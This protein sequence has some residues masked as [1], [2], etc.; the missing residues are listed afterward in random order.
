MAPKAKA[1]AGP[2]PSLPPLEEEVALPAGLEPPP[3]PQLSCVIAHAVGHAFEVEDSEGVRTFDPC[4]QLLD[5]QRQKDLEEVDP[6][7]HVGRE[8]LESLREEGK[9][10][11]CALRRK[12]EAEV[13][14][15]KRRKSNAAKKRL[16]ETGG[17]STP[18]T[19]S[20]GIPELVIL[21]VGYPANVTELEELCQETVFD[22]ASCWV[23]IYYAGVTLK[24]SGGVLPIESTADPESISTDVL[25]PCACEVPEVVDAFFDCIQR[26]ELG[27]NLANATIRTIPDSHTLAS[28]REAEVSRTR[29]AL[30]SVCT[31]ECGRR[32]EFKAWV[33]DAPRLRLPDLR[34]RDT[35]LYERLADSVDQARMDVPLLIHCLCEQVVATQGGGAGCTSMSASLAED[36]RQEQV[37]LFEDFMDATHNL[38]SSEGGHHVGFSSPQL[39]PDDAENPDG[40]GSLVPQLDIA[41]CRHLGQQF[42]GGASVLEAVHQVLGHLNG[43]GKDRFGFPAVAAMSESARCAQRNRFYRHMPQ[44]PIVECE[45]MLLL[46]E[47]EQ[48]LH[49]AQPEREWCLQDRVYHERIG[50]D[51]LLQI[52]LEAVRSEGFVK[53][54]Y[55]PRHD[56]LLLALH[57]R[58]L[59]GCMLWHAWMG[60]LLSPP[61][62]V[63][64]SGGEALCTVPTLNDWQQLVVG[65]GPVPKPP[66]RFLDI[67]A[68]ELGYCRIIEKIY[69]PSDGS[70]ILRTSLQ[71]GVAA[72][73]PRPCAAT[74]DSHQDEH[75]QRADDATENGEEDFGDAGDMVTALAAKPPEA[76]DTD[77]AAFHEVRSAK[78]VKD[79]L[80]FGIIEDGGWAEVRAKLR[81]A[82]DERTRI[83][84]AAAADA[85]A[86]EE[87][88]RK[89]RDEQHA[90][91][92][93]QGLP[94][95]DTDMDDMEQDVTKGEEPVVAQ[96]MTEL[97]I[98][99][100]NCGKLW[101]AL[102][103]GARYTVQMH[104]ARP[105]YQEGA[106][107]FEP[108]ES[109][110]GV[111]S[112]YASVSGLAVQV[113]SDGTVWQTMP[114]HGTSME[115]GGRPCLPGCGLDRE[116]VRTV[117][118]SGVLIRELL[119]GRREIYYPDGVFASRNPLF[120]ELATR[121]EEAR[122]Q[123]GE[124]N[125]R[126]LRLLQEI[127]SVYG[128]MHG[129]AADGPLPA[130]DPVPTIPPSENAKAHGLPGHW[131]VSLPTGQ[132][133]GRA[134]VPEEKAPSELDAMSESAGEADVVDEPP[135]PLAQQLAKLFAGV[136]V[137]EG[138]TIEYEIQ[139]SSSS[140]IIDPHTGQR[141][142]MMIE[143][144]MVFEDRQGNT[145]TC[146]FPDRTRVDSSKTD[147][148][149][150]VSI[151]SVSAARVTCHIHGVPMRPHV[152]VEV[153]CGDGTCLEVV[154]QVVH[155]ETG[156]LVPMDQ[157][158]AE[159]I[160]TNASVKLRHPSGAEIH[161]FGAG[162][163]QVIS[164]Y[165][166]HRHASNADMGSTLKMSSVYTARVD[167]SILSLHD[168]DENVFEVHGNQTLKCTL[169]VD[170]GEDTP[171]P[172]CRV[173]GKAY[174][175][176]GA[177]H[178]QLPSVAPDPRLF[179]IYGDGEAE[180]LVTARLGD[181]ILRSARHDPATVLNFGEPMGRPM[182]TCKCH[183]I[184]RT[185][186]LGPGHVV[187][188][189]MD[190]GLP[191]S[192]GGFEDSQ[193]EHPGG[194]P[195]TFTKFRQLIEYPALNDALRAEFQ[196]ALARHNAEEAEQHA[197]HAHFGQD[198]RQKLDAE[199]KTAR[200]VIFEAGG[201]A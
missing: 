181:E 99:D 178:L 29:T 93:A 6:L 157:S 78:V 173:P 72:T 71:C 51:Q 104:W 154:P 44:T 103:G 2:P 17:A 133:Y 32:A 18:E 140:A 123:P 75:V 62:A 53:T 201:G 168:S 166:A 1:P 39:L 158:D 19:D 86:A 80:T 57:H 83:D 188:P 74:V 98:E 68:R 97:R 176:P 87:E 165:E 34:P 111:F 193:I 196:S 65:T 145:K 105:W 15:R 161:S 106:F 147:D 50:G 58:A 110:P 119:S 120:S 132:V 183:T 23:M 189:P 28:K 177:E 90:S 38:I 194:P 107:T 114:H 172:R 43:P 64:S 124:A 199:E 56:C 79:D 162:E 16:I 30:L 25:V 94:P 137:D 49:G 184:L 89:A 108:T 42:P 11:A 77:P 198:P 118:P 122:Q 67:D 144:L 102:P 22:C 141:A 163:V 3:E 82:R 130:S 160:S 88:A 121:I 185:A 155:Q 192:L 46:H 76:S 142:R 197:R 152:K 190:G 81:S 164:K 7:T 45:R 13:L 134:R 27:S 126:L 91:R 73:F 150:D 8:E 143:G 100:L 20:A 36:A 170:I 148:G 174:V 26:A 156:E 84:E 52:L 5:R 171:S 159:A 96:S 149:V 139:Q 179:V 21:L 186:L 129:V 180:E 127:A 41:T 138:R 101:V 136:L 151:R 153:E 187:S 167:Q 131:R 109:K 70:V 40:G 31:A 48:L 9:S 146:L 4:T 182:E 85:A 14:A 92:L 60:D 54:A 200:A 47:F 66:S 63:T 55:M 112:T 35:E 59:K 175:H 61:G 10:L 191:P 135:V 24:K 33:Q 95:A 116:R 37:G 125:K 169:P 117:T 115:V 128:S 195:Q 69:S 12:V 113:F